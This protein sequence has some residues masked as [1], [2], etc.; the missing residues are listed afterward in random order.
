[1]NILSGLH[2]NQKWDYLTSPNKRECL[3]RE[4]CLRS[5]KSH[6]NDQSLNSVQTVGYM[7]ESFALLYHEIDDHSMSFAQFIQIMTEKGGP[8]TVHDCFELFE[9]CGNEEMY[10]LYSM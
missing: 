1:M 8:Q 3:G 4:L 2:N 9:N 5:L 7:L 6:P 10:Y